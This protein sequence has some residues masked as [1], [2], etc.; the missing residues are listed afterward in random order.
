M[1]PTEYDADLVVL[2]WEGEPVYGIVV[3]AQL[4]RDEDKR[5]TWPFYGMALRARKRC[6]TCVL[7]VTP[8]REVAEWASKPIA[9]GQP[10]SPF[11]PLVMGPDG[12][13]WVTDAAQAK[14]APELAVLSALAHGQEE[15][16][17]PV[18]MAALEAALGLDDE[19]ARLYYDLVVAALNESARRALE[20]TYMGNGT[21]EYQTEFARK[22]IGLG[23]AE[24]EAK[25]KAEGEAKGKA[26]GEAK[27]KAEAL[28]RIFDRRGLQVSE[29][30][31]ALILSATDLALLDHWIDRALEVVSASDVFE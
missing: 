15:G 11:V 7:V 23:R 25:G 30:Q 22:Y 21:Y 8:H 1:T 18:A 9:T 28:L 27:G 20:E 31:R 12:V 3:E 13:P 2:L 4:A 6:P 16:A 14:N 26:E 17:L 10:G 29:P 5:F 24:G 19:R